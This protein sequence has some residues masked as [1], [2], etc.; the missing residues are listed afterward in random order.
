[1]FF[2]LLISGL[3]LLLSPLIVISDHLFTAERQTLT[4]HE[5]WQEDTKGPETTLSLERRQSE[6]KNQGK[7]SKGGEEGR[8]ALQGRRR[9]KESCVDKD[10]DK[11]QKMK[12]RKGGTSLNVPLVRSMW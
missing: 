5:R 1:M 6:N 12:E 2:F 8:R 11:R 9:G 4:V 10:R 7:N 3:Y